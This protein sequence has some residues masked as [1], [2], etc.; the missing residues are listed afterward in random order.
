MT[1]NVNVFHVFMETK[2]M[3]YMKSRLVIIV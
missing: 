1:V 3:T 2:A